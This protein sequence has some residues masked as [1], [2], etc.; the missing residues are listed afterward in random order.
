MGELRDQTGTLPAFDARI[1][2]ATLSREASPKLSQV[3]IPDKNQNLPEA[4]A[5]GQPGLAGHSAQP[6]P[7]ILLR[8]I[9][10]FDL[11]GMSR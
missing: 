10:T 1:T 6:M 5:L 8:D 4:R 11:C 9:F 2:D 3:A 7:P